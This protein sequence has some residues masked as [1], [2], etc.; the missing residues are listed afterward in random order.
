MALEAWRE[1]GHDAAADEQGERDVFPPPFL[2]AQIDRQAKAKNRDN[3]G[4]PEWAPEVIWIVIHVT[5]DPI[6]LG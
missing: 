6:Q 3:I 4:S 2:D 5:Y 1:T